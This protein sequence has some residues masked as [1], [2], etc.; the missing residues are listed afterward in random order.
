MENGKA[1]GGLAGRLGGRL[2]TWCSF[3]GIFVAL[4]QIQGRRTLG[5]NSRLR[6]SCEAASWLQRFEIQPK[7]TYCSLAGLKSFKGIRFYFADT[8]FYTRKNPGCQ[9]KNMEQDGRNSNK[10]SPQTFYG[11]GLYGLQGKSLDFNLVPKARLELA[12][13]YPH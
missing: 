5:A 13:G 10:K 9:R 3:Q 4:V 8:R 12:R 2:L 7:P 11:R 1:R 6:L